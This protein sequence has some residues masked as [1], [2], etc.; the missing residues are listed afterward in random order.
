MPL[1]NQ[2]R[3]SKALHSGCAKRILSC[4]E[5]GLALSFDGYVAANRGKNS[6][7]LSNACIYIDFTTFDPCPAGRL[8]LD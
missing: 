3:F 5:F 4:G 7:R 1:S 2:I 6:A 8:S